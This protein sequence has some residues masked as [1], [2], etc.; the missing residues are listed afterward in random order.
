MIS[1]GERL[2]LRRRRGGVDEWLAPKSIPTTPAPQS[3][4]CSHHDY[5]GSRRNNWKIHEEDVQI[6]AGCRF[7]SGAIYYLCVITK[8]DSRNR[9]IALGA[10]YPTRKY[11]EQHHC[12]LILSISRLYYSTNHILMTSVCFEKNWMT[13]IWTDLKNNHTRIIRQV[14]SNFLLLL[15]LLKDCFRFGANDSAV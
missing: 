10:M 7:V 12:W 11:A 6:S 2:R 14:W 3:S 15:P 1:S 4:S 5:F 8:R 9:N 13:I